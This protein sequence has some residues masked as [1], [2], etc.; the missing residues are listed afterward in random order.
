MP[1]S[2]SPSR[3]SSC[4]TATGGAVT[5]S[6]TSCALDTDRLVVCEVKTRSSGRYGLP[7]E[8]VDPR[9]ARRIRLI[10]NAWLATHSVPWVEIRFD[11]LAVLAEPGAPVRLHHYPAA[12]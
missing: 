9:K 11:V 5:A 7:A 2:T 8:A 10:T 1:R 12:F 3:A 6:S 4:S